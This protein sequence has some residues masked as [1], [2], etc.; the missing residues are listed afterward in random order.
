[1]GYLSGKVFVAGALWHFL[2][3]LQS[4]PMFL[5]VQAVARPPSGFSDGLHSFRPGLSPWDSSYWCLS[6]STSAPA[7]LKLCYQKLCCH[8]LHHFWAPW[9]RVPIQEKRP[10]EFV[11][12]G[13]KQKH[14]YLQAGFLC[15]GRMLTGDLWTAKAAAFQRKELAVAPGHLPVAGENTIS[16]TCDVAQGKLPKVRIAIV[17][18]DRCSLVLFSAFHPTP[19]LYFICWR[20]SLHWG[21]PYLKH[22]SW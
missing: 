22:C 21:I 14:V 6:A 3:C 12:S 7:P 10:G 9:Q 17:Y 19:A 20:K 8:R 11:M 4:C 2:C 1:M 5:C 13:A 18:L 15:G 16:L